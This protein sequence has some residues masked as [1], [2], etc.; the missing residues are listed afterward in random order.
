MTGCKVLVCDVTHT[1]LGAYWE[2][3]FA[4]GIGRPVIFTCREDVLK[5]PKHECHPHFDTNHMKTIPWSLDPSTAAK[6]AEELTVTLRATLPNDAKL[7]DN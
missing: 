7:K 5:D 6:A 2:A 1:N 3:G 4:E